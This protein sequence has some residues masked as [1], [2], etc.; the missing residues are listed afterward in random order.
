MTAR[1]ERRRS[2]PAAALV[3]AALAAAIAIW[4]C[5][6]DD[7]APITVAVAADRLIVGP[8]ASVAL[9]ARVE[10]AD[11][12]ARLQWLASAGPV[13]GS[14]PRV[15]WV[16][17]DQ[18]GQY[19]I[20][21]VATSGKRTARTQVTIAVRPLRRDPDEAVAGAAPVELVSDQPYQIT[22]IELEK[23]EICVNESL[24]VKAA[25]VDP[26]GDA[27]WITPRVTI[28]GGT[29]RLGGETV[30]AVFPHRREDLRRAG[31]ATVTVELT[32]ARYPLPVAVQT[33]QVK[34]KD[35][36]EPA[37]G[38]SVECVAAL[39][40]A[41]VRCSARVQNP[42]VDVDFRVPEPQPIRFE[43]SILG[44]V[45]ERTPVTSTTGA[46]RLRL[47]ELP[48]ARASHAHAI[49]ARG[50][51]ADGRMIEGRDSFLVIDDW[52][53]QRERLGVL[54]LPVR[55]AFPTRDAAG[56]FT[57]PVRVRNPFDED[58]VIDELRVRDVACGEPGADDGLENSRP[59]PLDQVLG[60]R[61]LAPGASASF[62]W[63]APAAPG[64]C[65]TR[66]FLVGRGATTELPIRAAWDMPVVT[67]PP[68]VSD[69][70]ARIRAALA[71]LSQ[72]AGAP[73]TTVTLDQLRD[74]ELE[75]AIPSIEPEQ[76]QPVAPTP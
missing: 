56:T 38:L 23:S 37:A 65:A 24:G 3:V 72:R 71:I 18:P 35:C 73:V 47:P 42:K 6:G 74:L 59:G 28:E 52:F 10:G 21:V 58:V 60:T 16:A 68:V 40:P 22:S 76:P 8:R 4:R 46:A 34:I 26:S 44:D 15:R 57:M 66:G 14:G 51:F 9:T 43:W 30:V 67:R 20:D 11:G 12:P 53:E 29:G 62:T 19:T 36:E 39:D 5:G 41:D 70:A 32:D 31:T 1:H 7:P 55:Y 17:P 75:G 33:V 25:G 2:W 61:R 64:R 13:L 48:A 50:Y 69:E 63:T 45:T 54:V 27:T 49:R